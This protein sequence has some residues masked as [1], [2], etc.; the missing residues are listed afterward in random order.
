M[1]KSGN[2]NCHRIEDV[3]SSVNSSWEQLKQLSAD[4]G[5]KLR[6]SVVELEHNRAI[7][8]VNMTL[9]EI[10]A[11]LKSEDVGDSLRSVKNLIKRHQVYFIYIISLY[12]CSFL[13]IRGT[14]EER[15]RMAWP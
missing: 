9:E 2:T 4:K 5:I 8:D 3:L 11:Q 1:I 6:Q 13:F 15:G 7:E 10:S 14:G 12:L